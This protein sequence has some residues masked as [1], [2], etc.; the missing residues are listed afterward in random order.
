[1]NWK[2]FCWRYK[3]TIFLWAVVMAGFCMMNKASGESDNSPTAA[4]TMRSDGD[5]R[6]PLAIVV[7]SITA[8]NPL[9]SAPWLWDYRRLRSISL[10]N[11]SPNAVHVGTWSGFTAASPSW[12]VP[13]NSGTWTTWNHATFYLLLAP[14]ASTVTVRGLVE[15]DIQVN[16]SSPPKQRP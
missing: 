9:G 16:V 3:V 8:V 6:W 15:Y 1:M 10:I 5:G 2:E 7:T 11:P 12:F 14:N 4:R 13:V